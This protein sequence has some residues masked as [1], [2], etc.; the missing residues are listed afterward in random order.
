MEREMRAVSSSEQS[1]TPKSVTSK[2]EEINKSDVQDKTPPPGGVSFA[3]GK[4][5]RKK[6][7]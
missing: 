1:S 3:G 7:D 2:T 6:H 5:K 4:S